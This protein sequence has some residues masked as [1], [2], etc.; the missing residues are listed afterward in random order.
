[1]ASVTYCPKCHKEAYRLVSL[2]NQIQVI[3]NGRSVFT[4]NDQSS[5]NISLSCPANHPVKLDIK[6]K[7]ATCEKSLIQSL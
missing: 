7:E 1:M 6:P 3:Q 5:I 4:F 2:N